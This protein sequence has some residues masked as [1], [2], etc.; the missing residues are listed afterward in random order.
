MRRLPIRDLS[1]RSNYVNPL[2]RILTAVDFSEPARAAFDHALVLSRTH[3]A[4]LTVVHAVPGT[5]HLN[6]TRRRACAMIGGTAPGGRSGRRSLQGE[7]SAWRSGR[8]HPA[9]CAR[10]T[11][12]RD[13]ARHHQRSGFDRFRL[14]SVAETVTLQAT[15]PV[16]IVPASPGRQ[17][18][19]IRDVLQQHP[20]CG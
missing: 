9:A 14:G 17:D 16:L 12:G 20:G 6:G 8:R 5:G 7:R 18:R 15:Q 11:A 1:V 13:R 10:Q 2:T 19:R 4:E 3:N